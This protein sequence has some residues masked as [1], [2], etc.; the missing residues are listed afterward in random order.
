M[1]WLKDHAFLS[2]WLL[3]VVGFGG[4]LLKFRRTK[5]T[6]ISRSGYEICPP[7]AALGADSYR[8]KENVMLQI[9]IRFCRVIQRLH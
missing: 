9:S 2:D 5:P 7:K 6:Q 4:V 1:N 3:A 8:R